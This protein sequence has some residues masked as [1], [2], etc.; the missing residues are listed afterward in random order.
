[1]EEKKKIKISLKTT[2]LI[3]LIILALIFG[4]I[5]LIY[6][7]QTTPSSNSTVSTGFTS[8]TTIYSDTKKDIPTNSN[9][10]YN[11]YSTYLNYSSDVE[12]DNIFVTSNNELEQYLYKCIGTD[13]VYMKI[14]NE[15]TS[16]IEYF[17]DDFF[18]KH[19]LAIEM[20]EESSSNHNYSIISV[21]K[22]DTTGTINIKDDF[23]TYGGLLT[24]KIK[25]VFITLD[26]KIKN[27]NFDIYRTTTN[28]SYESNFEM[29]F[30]ASIIILITVIIIVSVIVS[31]HN[32]KVANKT[33]LNSNTKKHKPIKR[34]IIGIIIAVLTVIVLFFAIVFYEAVMMPNTI[35]Y[36]PIIYLYPT[37]EIKLSV[38]LGNKENITCSYP[39]YIDGWN[40]L[41]KTNG[42]LVDLNTKRTLYSLYYES[43]NAINFNVKEDG[44]IVQGKDT[45]TFLEVN[46]ARS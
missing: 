12:L 7:I 30:I 2:I 26:K 11:I 15:K 42:D 13:P 8:T 21:V 33:S 43:R 27:V 22:N 5:F 37:E 6:N 35:V 46:K 23:Y 17:N 45:I 14:E 39:Q 40:V 25:L 4:I 44:F 34:V 18:E 32:H 1:M 29:M 28:N 3:I 24:P 41:A 20:Y 36:K 9:T 38:G 16:I 10:K 19:N 31:R